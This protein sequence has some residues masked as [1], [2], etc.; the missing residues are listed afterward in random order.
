MHSWDLINGRVVAASLGHRLS[1]IKINAPNQYSTQTDKHEFY[2]HLEHTL[3]LLG[4]QREVITL[5]DLNARVGSSSK[6][7]G[8]YEHNNNLNNNRQRLLETYVRRT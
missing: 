1:V 7:V 2:D 4:Y 3:T 8:R 6:V 5:S